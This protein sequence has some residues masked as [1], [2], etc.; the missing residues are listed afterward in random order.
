[1]NDFESLSYSAHVKNYSDKG[2]SY[3][4][5]VLSNKSSINY[6][7]H[8]RMYS[9]LTPLI[10]AANKDK[11]L[12]VGDGLG[13]DANWLKEA[14]VAVKA[15]DI[16]TELLETAHSEGYIEEY[17]RENAEN[18][19][20]GNRVF[21]YVL[22]KEAFHHFPRPYIAIYEMLR[23][24]NKGVVLIE[25]VDIGIQM[26]TII[27]L[28]NVLDRI[29]TNLINKFWKNRYSFE[30]VGNYVYKVSERE[31]EKIAMGIN[32][33]VIAFKGINDYYSERLNLSAS[34][35]NKNILN[36]VKFRIF[37]R[38]VICKLG[39][40]PYQLQSCIVFKNQ[41]DNQVLKRLK[42]YGY[43]I[44]KLKRNP[45]IDSTS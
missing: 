29:S 24:A 17:S 45:Y 19:S 4:I 14:G 1:M 13:T 30:S 36:K 3:G 12:T 31:I 9:L 21:D 15:S 42:D 20:F 6:W 32:L 26:P 44:V 34:I 7:R 39:I 43:K 27:F 37:I 35:E 23:V 16:S 41:P 33:P 11:W 38:D 18:M 22:C 25:P 40:I 5:D 28:K 2:S 10:D 8:A